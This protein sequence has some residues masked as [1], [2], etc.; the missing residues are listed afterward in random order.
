MCLKNKL[1]SLPRVNRQVFFPTLLSN[2]LIKDAL[3]G[4]GKLIS[5][6]RTRGRGE[7][8]LA[9][10]ERLF[11]YLPGAGSVSQLL[12]FLSVKQVR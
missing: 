8:R 2:Y 9:H 12:L 5:D 1:K 4:T 10:G 3:G 6:N 11:M 7:T